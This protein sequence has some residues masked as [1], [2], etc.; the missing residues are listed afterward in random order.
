MFFRYLFLL[1]FGNFV[2]LFLGVWEFLSFLETGI[3]EKLVALLGEMTFQEEKGQVIRNFGKFS[4]IS[5]YVVGVYV[6]QN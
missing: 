3:N 6:H 5:N 1:I 2:N 4:N